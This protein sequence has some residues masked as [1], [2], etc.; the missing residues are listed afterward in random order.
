MRRREEAFADVRCAEIESCRRPNERQDVAWRVH[1]DVDEGDGCSAVRGDGHA[2][3]RRT[4][5]HREGVGAVS[6]VEVHA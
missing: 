6:C 1:D 3:A 4:R 2:V 5:T